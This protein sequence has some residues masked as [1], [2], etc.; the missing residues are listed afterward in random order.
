MNLDHVTNVMLRAGVAFAFLY[1]PIDALFDPYTWIGYLPHF[2]RGFVP[3]IVA[4]YS[5][6]ILE[7]LIAL[8]ILWGKRILMPSLTAVIILVLIIFLNLKDFQIIFRDIPIALMAAVLA[9]RA[10][11][12]DSIFSTTFRKR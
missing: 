1:P 8:W 12:S 3:D 9:I 6:G 7:I 4:L 11:F 5:F 2:V 10:F